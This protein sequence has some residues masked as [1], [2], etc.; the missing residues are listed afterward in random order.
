MGQ[1]EANQV[2]YRRLKYKQDNNS[3]FLFCRW[4]F[5]LLPSLLGCF[6]FH[7]ILRTIHSQ[8]IMD[9]QSVWSC[10]VNVCTCS[11]KSPDNVHWQDRGSCAQHFLQ[12]VVWK[13]LWKW[14]SLLFVSPILSTEMSKLLFL[15]TA[16]VL[17]KDK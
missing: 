6:I 14:C 7:I 10:W 15:S 13:M 9:V 12:I 17:I 16:C 4:Y 8:R 3:R 1:E 11:R 5:S 2:I